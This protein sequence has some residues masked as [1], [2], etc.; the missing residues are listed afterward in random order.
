MDV[1]G[2]VGAESHEKSTDS[3]SDDVEG[4][5]SDDLAHD[6]DCPSYILSFLPSIV[7]SDVGHEDVPKQRPYIADRLKERRDPFFGADH[8]D[9]VV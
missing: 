2:S 5:Q 4:D 8:D 1:D 9:S 7:V 6:A 3:N